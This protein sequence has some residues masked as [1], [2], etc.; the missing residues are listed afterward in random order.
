MKNEG[1]GIS[2]S[3]RNS[4]KS[5]GPGWIEAWSGHQGDL[6]PKLAVGA[7]PKSATKPRGRFDAGIV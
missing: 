6:M 7:I 2:W 5:E 3:F 1:G 4:R